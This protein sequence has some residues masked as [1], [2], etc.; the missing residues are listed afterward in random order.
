MPT[1]KSA[2][3]L[4][5]LLLTH[6][7]GVVCKLAQTQVYFPLQSAG[8]KWLTHCGQQHVVQEQRDSHDDQHQPARLPASLQVVG[9]P[10][11][12]HRAAVLHHRHATCNSETLRIAE[13]VKELQMSIR[14]QE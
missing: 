1:A 4:Y 12:T 13:Q 2:K 7:D 11:A 6:L 8:N 3:R 10:R 14:P 9:E 5:C